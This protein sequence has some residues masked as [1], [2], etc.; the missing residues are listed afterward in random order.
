MFYI[1]GINCCDEKEVFGN[2]TNKGAAVTFIDRYIQPEAWRK[3]SILPV[4]TAVTQDAET[5]EA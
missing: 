1:E 4:I 3:I 2:F 5:V